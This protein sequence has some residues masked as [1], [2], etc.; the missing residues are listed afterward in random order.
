MSD[1]DQRSAP[2]STP[3]WDG[4]L[5]WQHT[6]NYGLA[7]YSVYRQPVRPD[8]HHV[9]ATPGTYELLVPLLGTASVRQGSS[10]AEAGPGSM[11]L[12]DTDR[13]LTFA[14]DAEFRSIAF[15]M[16][17]QR[18]AARS[19]AAA[20]RVQVL[21]ASLGLGRVVRQLVT[22]L[23]D[24]RN[25]VSGTTFDDACDRLLD[26]VCMTA[27]GDTAAAP[28]RQSVVVEAEIRRYIRQHASEEDLNVTTI[29]AALGWSSRY[30]Q[31]VLRSASTTSR[32]LIRRERLHLARARL[33]A[34][35]WTGSSIAQVA[36]SC[37]FGSH[38]AFSTAF[39]KEFGM[40]PLEARHDVSRLAPGHWTAGTGRVMPGVH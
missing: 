2:G 35:G 23:P 11:I 21:D 29:A 36:H 6:G 10:A 13:P 1:G 33:T 24:V 27:E 12:C 3:S 32:D 7:L 31:Q 25:D 34:P 39:R 14:H 16:P 4:R 17:E 28:P 40:T 37:G 9:P 5:H 22:T 20:G 26:L 30:V 15:L 8:V 38:A 18:I 19:P